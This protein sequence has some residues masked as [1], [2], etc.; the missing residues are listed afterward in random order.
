MELTFCHLPLCLRRPRATAGCIRRAERPVFRRTVRRLPRL[1]PARIYH[2]VL[3]LEVLK[4]QRRILLLVALAASFRPVAARGPALGIVAP[5]E[6]EGANLVSELAHPLVPTREPDWI[7]LEETS[8]V[9]GDV[10]G[11]ARAPAALRIR[12]GAAVG[13]SDATERDVLVARGLQARALHKF[14]S[15]EEQGAVDPVVKAVPCRPRQAEREGLAAVA[16]CLEFT[17]TVQRY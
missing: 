14:R 5:F 4:E 17:A 1:D 11:T 13:V 9:A 15:V 10:A 16:D 6:T 3:R 12:K 2:Q 8:G 7:D